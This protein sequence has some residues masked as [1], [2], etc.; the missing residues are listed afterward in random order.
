MV[1]IAFS[2]SASLKEGLVTKVASLLER[3]AL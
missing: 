2:V 1:P 3:G